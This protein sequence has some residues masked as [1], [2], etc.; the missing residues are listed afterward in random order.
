MNTDNRDPYAC[1]S[2]I[3]FDGVFVC[4]LCLLPCCR[5]SKCPQI[6]HAGT[7]EEALAKEVIGQ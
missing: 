6:H 7:L 3:G 4:R 5:V 2:S 1:G